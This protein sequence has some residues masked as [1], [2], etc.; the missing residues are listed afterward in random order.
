M[1]GRFK[2]WGWMEEVESGV[3]EGGQKL[4]TSSYKMSKF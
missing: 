2:R 1:P 4:Q 3:G